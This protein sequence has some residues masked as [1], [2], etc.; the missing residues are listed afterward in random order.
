MAVALIEATYGYEGGEVSVRRTAG[1]SY[2]KITIHDIG[3]HPVRH[4][5]TSTQAGALFA[6]LHQVYTGHSPANSPSLPE[7]LSG[8]LLRRE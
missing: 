2:V 3:G 6:A 4:T 7:A 5:L 1:D 8:L